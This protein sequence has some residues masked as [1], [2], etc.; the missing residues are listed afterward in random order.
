MLERTVKYKNIMV[1]QGIKARLE[2]FIGGELNSCLQ[3]TAIYTDITTATKS[4]IELSK[5]ED[6][7]EMM[8]K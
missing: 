4:F 8:S 5:N 3:L 2:T 7:M 6:I 1:S